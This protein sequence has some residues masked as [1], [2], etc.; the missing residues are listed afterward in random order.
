MV[1]MVSY[2]FG[3][4]SRPLSHLIPNRP[5]SAVESSGTIQIFGTVSV[6]GALRSKPPAFAW[7]IWSSSDA[8]IKPLEQQ[9]VAR[10]P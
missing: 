10:L 4:E 7:W 3:H 8:Q 1:V 9:K 5:I 6:P 2:S